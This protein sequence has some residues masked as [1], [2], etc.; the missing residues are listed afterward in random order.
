MDSALNNQQRLICHKTQTAKPRLNL[1][2]LGEA[3]PLECLSTA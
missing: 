2:D 1:T 3:N